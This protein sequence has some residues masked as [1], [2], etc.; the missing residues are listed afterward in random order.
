MTYQLK[1]KWNCE[2]GV[3][4]GVDVFFLFILGTMQGEQFHQL[5]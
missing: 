2:L 5:A 4:N 1:N 3:E